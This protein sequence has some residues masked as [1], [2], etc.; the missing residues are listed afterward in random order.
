MPTLKGQN[1]RILTYDETAQKL[2]VFGLAT[3]CTVTLTNNT[4]SGTTKDDVGLADKPETV[5][6]AGSV[7][8]ESLNVV[9][10]AAFLTAVRT[11][12]EFTLMWD[13]TSTTDNQTIVNTQGSFAR[14]ATAIC[15]DLTLN[16]NN[17]EFAGKSVQFQLTSAPETT[18]E[19]HPD[20][21]IL[22]AGSKTRGQFVRLLLSSDNTAAPAA[23]IAGAQQLSMHV[24]VALESI[25]TKD[26]EG[27]WDIQ[28]ATGISYDISTTALIR[29]AD[30]ITS[31]VSGKDVAAIEAI[32]EAGTPVKWK[33]ANA[34]GANQRTAGTVI[35]SGSAIVTQL[36]LNASSRQAATYETQLTGY[37]DY[38]VG[39]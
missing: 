36:T 20:Q 11:F 32:H 25:S 22:P 30:V 38:T 31:S 1:V 16:F 9:D 17:R 2:T 33:I 12:K 15:N 29:A 23:V 14:K 27:N 18:D 7:Q 6:R 4:E 3:S 28:E 13:E 19:W 8:V 5:S 37:G 21:T 24:T 39:A 10:A 34:S 26:T 35:A